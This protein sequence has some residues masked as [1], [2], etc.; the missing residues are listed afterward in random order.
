MPSLIVYLDESGDLG[1]SFDR[2]YR[3]GGSSRHLTISSLAVS[4][5]AKDYPKRVIRKLYK[6][7]KWDTK[8]EKKWSD[9]NQIERNFFAQKALELLQ[10][11]PQS[12]NYHSI[13]VKKEN[14]QQ[15]IRSDANKLY[16]YMI[17][18]SLIDEMSRYDNVTFVPDPRSIKVQSGNSLHD[19]LLTQLWFERGVQTLL[20]TN[21][22]PSDQCLSLQFADMLSGLVQH[23]FEDG[24]SEAWNILNGQIQIKKLFFR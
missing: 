5:A 22:M 7:F 23:H 20:T 12:I 19:Y 11:N 2:P 17:C 16:N 1:W 15:H 4:P 24:N 21:P 14:V 13:T 6:K 10:S 18:L 3:A 9:M 8:V